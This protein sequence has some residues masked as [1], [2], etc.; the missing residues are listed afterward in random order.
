MEWRN[1]SEFAVHTVKSVDVGEK[2]WCTVSF[3]DGFCLAVPAAPDGSFPSVDDRL[4]LFGRGL[5]YPVRGIVNADTG[6]V[7]RWDR[8]RRVAQL[9][10]ER[11]TD[12]RAPLL[13]SAKWK[14]A[15]E[16][17]EPARRAQAEANAA[18]SEP[19]PETLDELIAYIQSKAPNG[20]T[21]ST[22]YEAAADAIYKITLAAHN[23][24]CSV[25]GASGF[26]AS[27]AQSQFFARARG[28]DGPFAVV[29]AADSLYPQ[30]D[31]LRNAR[32]MLERD[33]TKAWLAGE[34]A[35]KLS[36]S[37]DQMHPDV[38]AHMERLAREI[39]PGAGA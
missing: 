13:E 10:I 26:Q 4:S 11:E 19:R 15:R 37:L 3:D 36:A 34:A 16:A 27:W 23:Y 9:D 18:E 2:A 29:V 38:R 12:G 14:A 28:I 21:G 25:N 39:G 33:T 6:A 31:A 17:E 5:G 1:D 7:Y 35:K 32:D 22:G 30:N 8:R 24:A 20:A